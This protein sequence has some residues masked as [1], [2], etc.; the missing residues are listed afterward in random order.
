MN[1]TIDLPVKN[2]I[3]KRILTDYLKLQWDIFLKY[4]S[5]PE[6]KIDSMIEKE[7]LNQKDEDYVEVENTKDLLTMI[8]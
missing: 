5:I 1:I 7:I 3:K 8:K 4:Y 2:K 6:Y